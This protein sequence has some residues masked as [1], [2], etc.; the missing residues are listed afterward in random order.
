MKNWFIWVIIASD[1]IVFRA[2]GHFRHRHP[3]KKS[4]IDSDTALIFKLFT[5]YCNSLL[6]CT[7]NSLKM[8]AV[9]EVPCSDRVI[10]KMLSLIGLQ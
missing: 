1:Y 7:V 8:N 2:G 4:T 10:Y 9:S 5:V 3:F 6:H